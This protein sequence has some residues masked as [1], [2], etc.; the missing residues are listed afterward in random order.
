MKTKNVLLKLLAIIL[1]AIPVLVQSCKKTPSNRVVEQAKQ[2]GV[3]VTIADEI[4]GD[5]YYTLST[6]DLMQDTVLSPVGSGIEPDNITFWA[7]IYSAFY[8]GAFYYTQEGNIISKQRIVNGRYKEQ[9]NIVVGDGWDLGMMKTVFNEN[10]LNF[11]SWMTYY[12]ASENVIEK[13]LYVLDTARLSVKSSNKIK[14][15]FPKFPIYNSEGVEV[16]KED[17]PIT[18]SSFAIRDGKVFM[19]Y[20]YDW[21][22]K[23]DTAYMLVC[24]Y[25]ALNNVK[26][27]KDS[28]LGHVSGAWYASSSSFTDENGDYYFTTVNKNEKYGILRIKKGATEI[29]PTYAYDLSSIDLKGNDQWGYASS[30]YHAYLKNGVAFIGSHIID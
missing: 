1:L 23:L 26:L 2:Y 9:A 25:P 3:F 15:P 12:N 24:D 11:L 16:A 14:I 4:S 18:P 5:S 28:R 20:Y 29:D 10:G 7:D 6:D 21:A 13:T 27:L 8:N 17:V 22:T 19:G 30:D